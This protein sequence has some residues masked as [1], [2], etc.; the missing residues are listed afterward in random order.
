MHHLEA[1]LSCS[2]LV[3]TKRKNDSPDHVSVEIGIWG[4]R[5]ESSPGVLE[6]CLTF[7]SFV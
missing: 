1:C 6:A 4:S 5:N 2:S 7:S 3:E